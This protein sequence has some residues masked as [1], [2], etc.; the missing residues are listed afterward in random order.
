MHLRAFRGPR[1]GFTLLE[2]LV[3]IV[4]I[5]LLALLVAPVVKDAFERTR[6]VNCTSNL[7]TLYVGA[8]AYLI[9]NDG[10]WPQ[11]NPA[12]IKSAPDQYARAWM[13]TLKDYV[14]S[15]KS[16]ICPSVQAM[17]KNP[18]YENKPKLLRTDYLACPFDSKQN[19]ANRLLKQPW[20]IERADVHGSGNLLVYGDG[21][22]LDLKEAL[23]K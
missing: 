19:T 5:A 15:K 20:F 9:A 1:H 23:D 8:Q 13:N 6:R 2:L 14:P 7:R 11:I 18:D 12:L 17:L 16:W 10:Y 4:V 21:R 3:C 22:V